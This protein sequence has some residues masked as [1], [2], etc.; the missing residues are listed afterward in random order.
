[1]DCGFEEPTRREGYAAVP[2]SGPCTNH[3]LIR[4]ESKGVTLAFAR[5]PKGLIL[6]GIRPL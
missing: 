1:M 3:G 5:V 2:A 6:F 4:T